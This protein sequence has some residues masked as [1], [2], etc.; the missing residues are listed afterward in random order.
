MYVGNNASAVIFAEA[1]IRR[2]QKLMGLSEIQT[3][4]KSVMRGNFYL[5]IKRQFNQ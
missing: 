3:V 2:Y 1:V 5:R 4:G